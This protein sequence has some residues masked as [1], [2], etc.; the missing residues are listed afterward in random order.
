MK[1]QNIDDDDRDKQNLD[2]SSVIHRSEREHRF[3]GVVDDKNAAV[4]GLVKR[5]TAKQKAPL[6]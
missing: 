6:L 5:S 2:G 3:S 1:I 4:T